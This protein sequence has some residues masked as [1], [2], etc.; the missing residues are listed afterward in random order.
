MDLLSSHKSFGASLD[1]TFVTAC[2]ARAVWALYPLP[3]L[4]TPPK[5]GRRNP[6]AQGRRR[7]HQARKKTNMVRT[8]SIYRIESQK[9]YGLHGDATRSFRTMEEDGCCCRLL[10]ALGR[11]SGLHTILD[12]FCYE[13]LLNISSQPFTGPWTQKALEA[14]RRS[15]IM[16]AR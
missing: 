12:C 13:T 14:S 4:D 9:V 8:L 6:H 1:V 5:V 10:D 7:Q 16:D 3:Y 11:P 2:H 15:L